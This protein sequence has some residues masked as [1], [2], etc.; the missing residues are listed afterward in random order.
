MKKYLLF[1]LMSTCLLF[2]PMLHASVNMV[3]TTTVVM[4]CMN[5]HAKN[6]NPMATKDNGSC[7]FGDTIN[8]VV[9]YGCMSP[10]AKNFNP[11]ATR[12]NGSC[13]FDTINVVF[14]CT[15]PIALNFNPFARMGNHNCIYKTIIPGCMDS[16]AVNFNPKAN[17]KDGSCRFDATVWGC[18]DRKAMNFNSHA[19]HDNGYCRFDTLV[20][21]CTDKAAI[22]FNPQANHDNK[23]CVYTEGTKLGCTDKFALNFNRFANTDN[24][25]C[26]Y[27]V[28][29]DTIKGCTD[30][31][32]FN[33]NPIATRPNG[34]CIFTGTDILG[35]RSP[36]AL[37]YDSLATREDGSCIF[38]R[39]V[40]IIFPGHKPDITAI[41]DTLGKVLAASCNFDYTLTIDS[42]KI[43]GVKHLAN[44]VVEVAWTV[45]Q[46]S[47]VTTIK[48]DFTIKK[49]GNI[50]LYLSLVCN[51]G[52]VPTTGTTA[53]GIASDNLM[54]KSNAFV[55]SVAT[56]VVKGVTLSAYMSNNVISEVSNTN[57]NVAGVSLYPNPVRDQLS[58][59]VVSTGN[60]P[61]QL[62][63]YS[64]DGRKLSTTNVTSMDGVNRYTINTTSLG[65]GLHF[66]T[67]N[68]DGKM[69]QTVKFS[70]N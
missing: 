58:I 2:T 68:Q 57:S 32:A 38:A 36:K 50:L 26:V 40:N 62:I 35:C 52:V 53:S 34:K 49:H 13:I 10:K 6:F 11:K 21:G 12:E 60:N 30:R 27:E 18:T 16:L 42:A 15:D 48:T 4:G 5:P 33:F 41:A 9:V 39:P 47:T 64:V 7:V 56:D 44:N 37:N 61:L 25:S 19:N 28:V 55:G 3:D 67:I 22:N 59:S 1:S 45:Y 17:V 70:K 46:G 20:L 14:G 8:T 65:S 29:S 63:V 31:K 23:T 66:L 24:G 69:L 43:S 54:S 51:Q